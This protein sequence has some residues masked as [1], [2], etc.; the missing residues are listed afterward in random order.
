MNLGY[1]L[2]LTCQLLWLCS[3]PA[4][5]IAAEPIRILTYNIRYD[6]PND[7]EN[8]WNNR[9]DSVVETIRNCDIAGLQEVVASQHDFI[10]KNTPGWQWYGI[11]RDDG[12]RRGE[13]TSIGWRTDKLVAIEQATFWLSE[14]SN[15]VGKSG[16]DAALPRIASWVRFV[17][18]ASQTDVTRQPPLILINTHFDHRGPEARRQSA[19]LLKQFIQDRSL[20]SQVVLIG[21][22]NARVGSP[23]LNELLASD[24]TS[25]IH[26]LDARDHAETPDRGPTGTWNGFLQIAADNRIDHVLFTGAQIKILDY[27][28]LDPRTEKGRFAS[29]HLPIAVK[30]E[31]LDSSE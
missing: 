23:P 27:Q 25:T 29:D 18:L 9:K 3:A 28:T 8:I 22:L 1:R 5:S 11:G 14:N 30:I 15:R 19:L 24:E 10:S 16:W 13:M 31:L 21:D 26:L 17:P 12:Y 4:R 20:D 7:G 2:I 6:N